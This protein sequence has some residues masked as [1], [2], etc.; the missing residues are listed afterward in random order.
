MRVFPGIAFRGDSPRRAWV[1]GTGLDVWQIVEALRDFGSL[2]RLVAE[3]DLDEAVARLAVAYH[4]RF[5][6]EVDA[7]IARNRPSL[8]E[9]REHYPT[10]GVIDIES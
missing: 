3:S 7:M 4:E 6:E 8:E 1:I 5:P 10:F 2:D 9:L